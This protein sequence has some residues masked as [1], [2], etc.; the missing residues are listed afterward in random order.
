MNDAPCLSSSINFSYFYTCQ[1]LSVYIFTCFTCPLPSLKVGDKW[2]TIFVS[3]SLD[4]IHLI[5]IISSFMVH[6]YIEMMKVEMLLVSDGRRFN[7]S[8]RWK[9]SYCFY[10]SIS[11]VKQ[12]QRV[13]VLYLYFNV[14]FYIYTCT[15]IRKYTSIPLLEV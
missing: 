7:L 3:Y 15:Q 10:P 2:M 8:S 14:S 1:Q 5:N 6:L 9:S 4:N 13:K 12:V 11:K